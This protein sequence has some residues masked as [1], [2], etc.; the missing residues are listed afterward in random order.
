MNKEADKLM[1]EIKETPKESKLKDQLHH[2]INREDVEDL[3]E[4]DILINE[5]LDKINK[6]RQI[7][8]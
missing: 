2:E 5:I 4:H 3:E 8:N 7:H 1:D 6:E